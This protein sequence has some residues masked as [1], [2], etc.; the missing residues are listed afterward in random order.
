MELGTKRLGLAALGIV[1]FEAIMDLHDFQGHFPWPHTQLASNRAILQIICITYT[2]I[3][4]LNP[5]R[6]DHQPLLRR[7]KGFSEE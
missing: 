6:Q 4:F 1:R 7:V 2:R 3:F 5:A